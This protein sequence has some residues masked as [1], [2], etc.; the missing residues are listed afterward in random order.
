VSTN[1]DAPWKDEE[2]LRQKYYEEDLTVK[3][4]A[5][6]WGT[7]YDTIRYYKDKFEI[8]NKTVSSRF[9]AGEI[10]R[11]Y[12]QKDMS[13][14]DVGDYYDACG[15]HILRFMKE[16]NIPR[17]TPDHEKGVKWK[18]QDTLQNLYWGKGMTLEE[19]GDELGCSASTVG[20]WMK[21][22]GIERED[23]PEKKPPS[24]RTK[25]NGYETV[26]SKHNQ[27]GYS[28]GIHQLIAIANGTDPRKL[29]IDGYNVHHKN[30]IRWDNRPSNLEVM[31]KSEHHKHHY[32]EREIGSNGKIIN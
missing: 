26:R 25:K 16:N 9:D 14:N 19:I 21:R 12:W 5:D 6:L 32:T 27:R 23:T 3:E 20:R 8:P 11:L 30:G 15:T 1:T 17:R 2:Q 29:F 7:T 13:L 28:V 10:D 31:S 4:L 22:F 24:Y 18:N